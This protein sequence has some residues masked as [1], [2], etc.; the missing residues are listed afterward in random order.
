MCSDRALGCRGGGAGSAAPERVV[1]LRGVVWRPGEVELWR[2]WRDVARAW[3]A[4]LAEPGAGPGA[5]LLAHAG[6]AVPLCGSSCGIHHGRH[7]SIFWVCGV[8]YQ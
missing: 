2:L 1:M 7:A 8:I 5:G 6:A 4:P 3:P